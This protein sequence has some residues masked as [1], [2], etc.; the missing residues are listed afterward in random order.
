MLLFFTFQYMTYSIKYRGDGSPLPFVL[1]DSLGL[2]QNAGLRT[3]D[4]ASILTGHI[5]DR[6]Q[7]SFD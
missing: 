6:Y 2:S 3:D 4:L 5:P 7:V 1:C